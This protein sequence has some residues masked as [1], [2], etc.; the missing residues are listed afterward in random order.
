M[1]L[2]PEFSWVY[3]LAVPAWFA[4][5]PML[6]AGQ[7][8]LLSIVLT[9]LSIVVPGVLTLVFLHYS[10]AFESYLEKLNQGDART[11]K[12]GRWFRGISTL[13]TRHGDVRTYFTLGWRVHGRERDYKLRVSLQLAYGFISPLIFISTELRDMSFVIAQH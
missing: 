10:G 9:I 5:L 7:V 8:N 11:R 6:F 2:A 1:S 4:G 12:L 13:M 3:L